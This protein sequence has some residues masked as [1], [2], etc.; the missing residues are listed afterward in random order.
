MAIGDGNNPVFRRAIA[1]HNNFAQYVPM[2]LLL[3]AFAELNHA[4][5]LIIQGLCITLLVGR[6]IHAYGVSQDKENLKLRKMGILLTGS[7]MMGA[8]ALIFT[9]AL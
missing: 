3:I 4:S 6:L 8:I 5:T 1:V 9:Q 2:C 7:V